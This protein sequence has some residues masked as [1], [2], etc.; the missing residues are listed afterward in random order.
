LWSLGS[1]WLGEALQATKESAMIPIRR[2]FLRLAGAAVAA[3]AIP[4]IGVAQPNYPEKPI[5]I[6][7]GFAAGGPADILSRLLGE[8]LSEAW[9]KPVVVES[10][11]G[12]GGNIATERVVKAAPDGH[13]LLMAASAMIVVNPSLYKK[14]SFDPARD[15]API[16]QVGFTPNILVVHNDVPARSVDELVGLARA[17]PSQLTFGSGGVGSSNHLSGELL[18]SMARI[19]MQHV[20]Y[21]G[22]VQAVPDLLGGRLT[23]LFANAPNVRPLVREGKLRGLAVTS[24]KRSYA[25]SELP[26]MAEVGFPGFDVTAWF[27]LMA[28]SATPPAI[29]A[30]LHR[31]TVRATALPDVRARLEENGIEMIGG[32][33]AEFAAVIRSESRFWAKVIKEAGVNLPH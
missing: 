7:V 14:L 9:G 18:K 3:S 1:W 8:K 10:V 25:A 5:R 27:G 28:P 29:I 11:T 16:S 12:A 20:P 21:R 33:P 30:K 31:E 17:Q 32:S 13:T 23:M 4:K 2:Q 15:L 26:T 6:F 24:P 19:D 22:I